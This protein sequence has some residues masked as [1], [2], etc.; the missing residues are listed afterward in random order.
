VNLESKTEPFLLKETWVY[1]MTVPLRPVKS[2][3]LCHEPESLIDQV[4][5]NLED[6]KLFQ[7][8]Y[9]KLYSILDDFQKLKMSEFFENGEII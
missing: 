5:F 7:L 4:N 2:D 8:K 9:P 1:D 3:Q 6:Q